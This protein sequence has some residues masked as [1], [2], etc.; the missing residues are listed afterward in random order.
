MSE[1]QNIVVLAFAGL[2]KFKFS[3]LLHALKVDE[4]SFLSPLVVGER[5][6]SLF[7]PQI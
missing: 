6:L 1:D 7:R 2:I 3:D 4:L 5:M